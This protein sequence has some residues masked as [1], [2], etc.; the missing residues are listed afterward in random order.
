MLDLAVNALM[1]LPYMEE[2]ADRLAAAIPRSAG[3]RVFGVPAARGRTAQ[4][5]GRLGLDRL[6]RPRGAGR[7]RR[8]DRRRA[9]RDSA[10]ADGAGEARAT[11]SSSKN[12]PIPA[13]AT[14]PSHLHLRLRTVALDREGIMPDAL[15]EACREGK[16]A[17]L[18]CIPSF[19]NPTAA[20]MSETRRH[21]DCGGGARTPADGHR[22]RRLRISRARRQAAV[23]LPAGDAVLLHHQ[24]V[25]EHRAGHPHRLSAGARPR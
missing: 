4:S 16:P 1:P 21:G 9:A 17:A 6:G 7:S 24:H 10:V 15:D 11:R 13:S 8:R 23:E 19:Q 18:Y 25:E 5:R 12:S 20:L 22:R 14:S 3:A 2:L